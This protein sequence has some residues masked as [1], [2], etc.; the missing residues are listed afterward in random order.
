MRLS[1]YDKPPS[2]CNACGAAEKDR[3]QDGGRVWK[4]VMQQN[5]KPA[6]LGREAQEPSL[7]F[8]SKRKTWK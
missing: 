1:A 8:P 5:L 4:Q 7:T 2:F 3:G 6:R